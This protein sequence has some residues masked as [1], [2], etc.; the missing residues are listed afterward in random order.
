MPRKKSKANYFTSDTEKYIKLYNVA[1]DA[2]YRKQI[3]TEHIYYPFYK[4]AENIIHTFKFYYTDV[5]KIEDLKHEVVTMLMSEKINKFDPENGAKAYSY[6]GTIVK[7]W[8]INYNNKNYKR[9]KQIGS[10]D[11]MDHSFDADYSIKSE[12]AITLSD[13]LD[14]WIEEV[15]SNIGELF[16]KYQ[17]Q[18]IADAVL[19]VFK[20]RNDL[21]IFKKKA[22]YIYIREMTD[23]ETPQLTRVISV[24]KEDFY[25]KFNILNEEGLISVK[26]L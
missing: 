19:T 21:E 9:L 15:Y 10:F 14:N 7:R 1:E 25:S 13:F 3:F 23:C 8:L 5:E 4:L 22:L 20:T 16:L 24:L 2:E 26:S 17:E 12:Y 6:F 18:Q 11:D